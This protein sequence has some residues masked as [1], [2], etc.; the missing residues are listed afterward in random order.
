MNSGAEKDPGTDPQLSGTP[1]VCLSINT[2]DSTGGS[3][4]QADLKTFTALGT[5]GVVVVSANSAQSFSRTWNLQPVSEGFL[6]DQLE[7]LDE[8]LAVS[9]VKVG[10][11]PSPGLIRVI[12]RWLREHPGIPT[13]V[14]PVLAT[15]VGIPNLS[16]EVISALQQELLPR[17]TVLTPNR[18]EAAQLAGMDECLVREDMEAAAKR[19]FDSYGCPTVITGGGLEGD[20][21]DVFCGMDGLSHFSSPAMADDNGR[22]IG[23]GCTYAAALTAELARGEALREA[24]AGAK[25]YV[26]ELIAAS[27]PMAGKEDAFRPICHCLAVDSLAQADGVGISASGQY[28]A[29]GSDQYPTADAASSGLHERRE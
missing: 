2:M 10:L 1:P 28:R 23:A 24:I 5:Y 11:C 21:L 8:S 13:V 25:S 9:A 19:L 7:A 22:V 15:Q 20:R 18:I 12:G 29:M 4:G 17:A 14:D 3:L 27:P 16:P 26:R 6:R